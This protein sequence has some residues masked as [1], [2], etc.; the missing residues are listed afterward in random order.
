MNPSGKREE[1]GDSRRP[2]NF[3]RRLPYFEFHRLHQCHQ[4]GLCRKSCSDERSVFLYWM[5]THGCSDV[6][7]C[8]HVP[9][10]MSI[11]S[12]QKDG[13]KSLQAVTMANHIERPAIPH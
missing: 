8:S 1:V 13:C 7:N 3:L 6:S 11:C 2:G 5:R 4:F 10:D 12:S 9:K